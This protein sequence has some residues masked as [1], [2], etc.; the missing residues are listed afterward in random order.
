[1]KRT[2]LPLLAASSL[3][4]SC[5]ATP[6]APATSTSFRPDATWQVTDMNGA[7]HPVG[8][9]LDAGEPVVLVFWQTWCGSCVEEAPRVEELHNSRPDL[10]VLGVVSGAAVDVSE[11]EV[12]RTALQLGL[13]Y[14]QVLD[15]DLALTRGFGVQG[16]PTIIV[17]GADGEVLYDEHHLPADLETL[18]R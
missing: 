12:S 7:V 3:F 16:T 2:L 17:V 4:A 11:L 15:R 14:P 5:G 10:H 9:W 8:A 18:G 13:T 1:M 6:D